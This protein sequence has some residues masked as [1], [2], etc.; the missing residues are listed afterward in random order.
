[1][2][3]VREP[4]FEAELRMGQALCA[5]GVGAGPTRISR[6]V[7]A[8]IRERYLETFALRIEEDQAAGC[9]R[10]AVEG[11]N[12]LDRARAIGRLAAHLALCE[13]SMSIEPRHLKGAVEQVE[14]YHMG[15]YCDIPPVEER[16][17][18]GAGE[19][20]GEADHARDMH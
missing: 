6:G 1:M 5:F 12:V 4:R 9:D 20:T 11:P 2:S 14:A 13:G 7:V 3:K 8:A 16:V 10:W 18:I 19:K 17:L 15:R